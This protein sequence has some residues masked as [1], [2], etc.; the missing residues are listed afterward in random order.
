MQYTHWLQ[1]QF[2]PLAFFSLSITFCTHICTIF[3]FLLSGLSH[4]SFSD[5]QLRLC[6]WSSFTS[7]ASCRSPLQVMKWEVRSVVVF[8][9]K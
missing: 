4:L 3:Y 1:A 8:I 5:R 2:S 7:T 9:D 6:C